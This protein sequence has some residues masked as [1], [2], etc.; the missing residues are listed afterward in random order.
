MHPIQ[1]AFSWPHDKKNLKKNSSIRLHLPSF[2]RLNPFWRYTREIRKFPIFD[3]PIELYQSSLRY[4]G[5]DQDTRWSHARATRAK[6]GNACC[7]KS[8][9]GYPLTGFIS[10]PPTPYCPQSSSKMGWPKATRNA[11]LSVA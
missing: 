5:H 1:E 11:Q 6:S 3:E 10:K 4:I 2:P 7:L 9:D 8:Q